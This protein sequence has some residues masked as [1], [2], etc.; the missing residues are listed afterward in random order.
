M[1]QSRQHVSPAIARLIGAT[2]PRVAVPATLTENITQHLQVA[3][4]RAM[5]YR[6]PFTAYTKLSH[7]SKA[8]SGYS[9]HQLL[10]VSETVKPHM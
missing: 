4:S 10:D 9:Q 5:K 8:R 1:R 6:P 3:L 7:A 2:P